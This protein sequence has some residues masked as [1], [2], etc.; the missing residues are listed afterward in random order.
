[1]FVSLPSLFSLPLMVPGAH[2]PPKPSP[3]PCHLGLVTAEVLWWLQDDCGQCINMFLHSLH[4]VFSEGSVTQKRLTGFSPFDQGPSTAKGIEKLKYIRDQ[5][6]EHWNAASVS[7]GPSVSQGRWHPVWNGSGGGALREGGWNDLRQVRS[8]R[9]R[10]KAGSVK[11]P[12]RLKQLTDC[13]TTQEIPEQ[14][15]CNRR[16]WG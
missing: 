2:R 3:S 8:S 4:R 10:Q 9:G 13:S 11:S 16:G 1:M 14:P 6:G 15:L 5:H 12:S 7:L